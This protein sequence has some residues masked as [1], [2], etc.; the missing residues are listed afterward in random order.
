MAS[1][2]GNELMINFISDSAAEIGVSL[3]IL[4]NAVQTKTTFLKTN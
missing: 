3:S 4:K 2:N 1:A